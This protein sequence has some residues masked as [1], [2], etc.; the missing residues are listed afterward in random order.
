MS[1]EAKEQKIRNDEIENQLRKDRAEQR[2]EVK[3]LLLGN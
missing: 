2:N 3:M 1:A